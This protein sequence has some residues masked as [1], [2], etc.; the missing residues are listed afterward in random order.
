MSA[1]AV[2]VLLTKANHLRGAMKIGDGSPLLK[3]IF[4]EK[5]Q[6]VRYYIGKKGIAVAVGSLILKY[7]VY[8]YL[9]NLDA[10]FYTLPAAYIFSRWAY[11]F[12]VFYFPTA[13]PQGVEGQ[14][15]E[16]FR[17][18]NFYI[19]SALLFVAFCVFWQLH[20]WITLAISGFGIYVLGLSWLRRYNG[21]CLECY[22]AI[23][24]W[25]EILFLLL[26]TIFLRL[27]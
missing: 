3:N 10:I 13:R 5:G 9:I 15:K 4:D 8:W 19:A 2:G 1:V 26:Y 20:F 24:E 25:S 21:L 14:L 11:S 17:R 12:A 27:W 18:K 23:A 6:M 7:L 16:T 22:D